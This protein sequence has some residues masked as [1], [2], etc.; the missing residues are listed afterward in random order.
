M[1]D[2]I[3]Y[4]E[5]EHLFSKWYKISLKRLFDTLLIILN[6]NVHKAFTRAYLIMRRMRVHQRRRLW[7]ALASV[8]RIRILYSIPDSKVH[9]A[10]MGPI[11]GRQDPGGPHVGPM[12][13]AI[14]DGL[15]R[16]TKYCR[17]WWRWSDIE[18]AVIE[19]Y[20]YK[21][22]LIIY[23]NIVVVE[24]LSI[25]NRI[26]VVNRDHKIDI[27]FTGNNHSFSGLTWYGSFYWIK[28]NDRQTCIIQINGLSYSILFY[29]HTNLQLDIIGND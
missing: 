3:A 26:T 25:V 1:K 12:N 7:C 18:S 29:A 20:A 4:N 5:A 22:N 19:V 28:I 9:G 8:L 11:S 27:S 2:F 23:L 13:F 17:Q 6:L 21:I 10:N 14:G 24:N 16:Q 15:E